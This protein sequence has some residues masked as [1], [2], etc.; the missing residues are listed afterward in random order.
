MAEKLTWAEIK[1]KYPNQY[2]ILVA[3]Q[4]SPKGP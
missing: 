4:R 2:V 1:A 3:S